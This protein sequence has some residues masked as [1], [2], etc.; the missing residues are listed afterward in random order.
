ML[1][2]N[3]S[4]YRLY[5]DKLAKKQEDYK[6]K[7]TNLLKENGIRFEDAMTFKSSTLNN[8]GTYN[9]VNNIFTYI[10]YEYNNKSFIVHQNPSNTSSAS[11]S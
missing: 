7:N 11:F 10:E 5:I 4:E 8:D 2:T 3:K 9:E 1:L 6:E